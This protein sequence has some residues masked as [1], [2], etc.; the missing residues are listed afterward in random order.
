MGSTRFTLL[1]L[2]AVA[3][4]VAE[5]TSAATPKP[6]DSTASPSAPASSQ[7][8]P[9]VAPV[10]ITVHLNHVRYLNPQ[11][12]VERTTAVQNRSV[13]D[14]QSLMS[15]SKLLNQ[16]KTAAA[17]APASSMRPLSF[18]YSLN[19]GTAT[20]APNAPPTPNIDQTVAA[21]NDLRTQFIRMRQVVEAARSSYANLSSALD[22]INATPAPL[23][24]FAF[25]RTQID[26]ASGAIDGIVASTPA[27]GATPP[28]PVCD[29]YEHSSGATLLQAY[30]SDFRK[31]LECADDNANYFIAQSKAS[32]NAGAAAS[33]A[34]PQAE[35]VHCFATVMRSEMDTAMIRD[36]DTEISKCQTALKGGQTYSL[37]SPDPNVPSPSLVGYAARL[38][39]W[40]T[41]LDQ[42]SDSAAPGPRETPFYGKTQSISL[43]CGPGPT[44]IVVYQQGDDLLAVDAKNAQ[45]KTAIAQ[46]DCS[47]PVQ[48]VVGFGISTMPNRVPG[49]TQASPSPGASAS[50]KTFYNNPNDGFTPDYL[51][52][53]ATVRLYEPTDT[54]A[55]YFN[56]LLKT[57]VQTNDLAAFFGPSFLINKTFFV[58]PGLQV[59]PTQQFAGGFAPGQSVPSNVTSAPSFSQMTIRPGVMFSFP[60]LDIGGGTPKPSATPSTSPAPSATK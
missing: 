41:N 18:T 60:V 17:P 51:W 40:K 30:P 6:P 36:D 11:I 55:L 48:Y 22:T 45:S 58:S 16:A 49:I 12:I 1:C 54:F 33:A 31:A 7:P 19:L 20:A 57:T 4:A 28:S 39:V 24:L 37:P 14:L 8:T 50:S 3:L 21:V 34:L 25:T 52:Q 26:A 53:G 44:H 23:S 59:G 38:D 56:V 15:G 29:Y 43:T 9:L 5:P 47:K 35:A 10:T 13:S 42:L 32:A 46:A 27:P 2:F